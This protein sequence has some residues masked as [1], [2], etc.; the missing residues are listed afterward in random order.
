M[1][2]PNGVPVSPTLTNPTS[3]LTLPSTTTAYGVG[4][5]MASSATAGS[6]VVPSFTL[7]NTGG[8]IQALTLA[9]NDNTST[10]Y[11]GMSIQVDLWDAA[12]TFSNGD[13]GSYVVATGSAYYIASFTC[14]VS[15]AN[16]DGF[17]ARCAP[18]VGNFIATVPYT[19]KTIY[20]T[21]QA[22]TA[23][24]ITGASKVWTLVA[25]VIN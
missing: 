17:Y 10:A 5:L 15:A 24:G 23:G 6:V 22:I 11:P 25:E 4:K 7:L 14:T 3:T 8:I 18:T 13:R 1:S 12:P 16:G 9:S 21:M 19:A 2:S 20:W